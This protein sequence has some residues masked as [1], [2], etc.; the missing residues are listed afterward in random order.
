M[1]RYRYAIS[2]GLFAERLVGAASRRE[3]YTARANL[4]PSAHKNFL[5]KVLI[6][7]AFNYVVELILSNQVGMMTSIE[8][9]NLYKKI[10]HKYS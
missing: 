6:K 5:L 9:T 7:S 3:A 4:L 8:N 1:T 2:V 10:H